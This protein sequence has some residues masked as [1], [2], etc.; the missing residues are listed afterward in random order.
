MSETQIMIPESKI[1][2]CGPYKLENL[3]KNS[4][5]YCE[6]VLHSYDDEPS[7]VVT[8]TSR[9]VVTKNWHK[10]GELHR[11]NGPAMVSD[12]VEQWYY[13]GMLHRENGPAVSF[14]NGLLIWYKH[15]KK[16]REGGPAVVHGIVRN[17]WWLDGER[18]CDD[19]PAVIS[20]TGDEWWK[21]G[22]RYFEDGTLYSEREHMG[23]FWY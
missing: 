11:E 22:K 5:T 16:H 19:G 2:K 23:A 12:G 21:H 10:H 8:E 7:L 4:A 15:G 14:S 13:E 6:D 3:I 17:E 18:H 1:V 20:F 9:G